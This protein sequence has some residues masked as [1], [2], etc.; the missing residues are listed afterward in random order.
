MTISVIVLGPQTLL[1][2]AGPLPYPTSEQSGQADRSALQLG[3]VDMAFTGVH[4]ELTAD[5]G[6]DRSFNAWQHPCLRSLLTPLAGTIP[7]DAACAVRVH[8]RPLWEILV[9]PRYATVPIPSARF[10]WTPWIAQPPP[11]RQQPA[12]WPRFDFDAV[13]DGHPAWVIRATGKVR[14]P[15]DR[16]W[17][18]RV[19][20]SIYFPE[21]DTQ[22]SI[23]APSNAGVAWLAAHVFVH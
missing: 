9:S 22:V 11:S 23:L 13:V 14:Y 6:P 12:I 2:E 15:C 18:R 20:T 17:V 21:R 4:V 8:G 1:A 19:W 5:K 7:S 16:T 10:R 3:H